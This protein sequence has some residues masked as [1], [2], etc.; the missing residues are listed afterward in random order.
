MKNLNWIIYFLATELYV[1]LYILDINS[2]SEMWCANIFCYSVGY[3][4]ILLIIFFAVQKP[5]SL[6]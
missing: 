2:L 6:I 3:L 5:V 1:F 4:F